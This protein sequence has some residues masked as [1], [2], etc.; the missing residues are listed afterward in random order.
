MGIV[1]HCPGGRAVLRPHSRG[2]TGA[3]LSFLPC[4]L[5]A[6]LSQALQLKEVQAY[7]LLLLYINM[8]RICSLSRTLFSCP[9]ERQFMGI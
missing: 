3:D 5:F 8:F 9:L 4:L 6:K 7:I 2:V 1:T